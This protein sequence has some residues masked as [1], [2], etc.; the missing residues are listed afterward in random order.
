MAGR[1]LTNLT[2]KQKIEFTDEVENK[3]KKQKDVA[4]HFGV[5]ANTV[6]TIMKSKDH[7][8]DIFYS[9]QANSNTQSQ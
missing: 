6:L 7:Y 9:G 2:L 4:C 8:R 1:I 3:G 5:P